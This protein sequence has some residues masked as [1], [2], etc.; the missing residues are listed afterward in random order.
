MVSLYFLNIKVCLIVKTSVKGKNRC[1][2]LAS[3]LHMQNFIVLIR[4]FRVFLVL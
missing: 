2:W 3:D 1:L 4:E